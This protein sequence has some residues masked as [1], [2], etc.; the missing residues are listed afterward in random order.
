MRIGMLRLL[1][2]GSFTDTTIDL[3]TGKTDF[4][5]IFGPN[6]AGKSTTLRAIRHM[7]FGIPTRTPDNFVHAYPQLRIGARLVLRD[8]DALDFI[9]RKGQAK[10]LRGLD[11]ETVLD[12]DA[13]TPFLGGVDQDLFEQMFA[14]GHEDLVRGGEE[15]IS[16]K[17]RIGEALFAAG[18]GLIRLQSVQQGLEQACGELFK[19]SGQAPAIN[20][21]IAAFKA[22]RKSQKEALLLAGTWQSHDRR[23]RQAQERLTAVQAELAAHRQQEARWR[24]IKEALP[25]IARKKELV[26]DLAS[27]GHVPDLTEDFSRKRRDGEQALMV[28]RRDHTHFL[29]SIRRLDE[30]IAGLEVPEIVLENEAAIEALQHDLGS[31]RKAQKDRPGLEGRRRTLETQAA[32]IIESLD[33][34]PAADAEGLRRLPSSLV[35][36]IQEL[37]Q[38]YERLTAGQTAI[39]AQQRKRRARLERLMARRHS[40]PTPADVSDLERVLK[41]IQAN[42]PLENRRTELDQTIRSLA[43]EQ[44]RR[45]VRQRLWTGD[46]EA[47]DTLALPSRETIDRFADELDAIRRRRQKLGDDRD[48]I[49]EALERLTAQRRELDP[50]DSV[51]SEA[52]LSAAR[53]LRGQGWTLIRTT[54]ADGTVTGADTAAFCRQLG[55]APGLPE[56]FETSMARADG[57]ADRLR[58]EADQV[59][60]KALLA[61]QGRQLED[62]LQRLAEELN[63]TAG[64]EDACMARW[65]QIWSPMAVEPLSPT[66]MRVWV[67]DMT[68][69][70]ERVVEL[71]ALRQRLAALNGQHTDATRSLSGALVAAGDRVDA[72]AALDELVGRAHALVETQKTLDS[73]LS[74]AD[75]EIAALQDEVADGDAEKAAT[76]AE[77]ATWRRAWEKKMSRIGLGGDASPAAALAVIDSLREARGKMGEADVLR[78]RIDGIDRDA[79][80]FINR[81]GSLVR[82][83]APDLADE[84]ADRAAEML[85]ARLKAARK[86][87]SVHDGLA[88]QRDAAA[89]SIR[90]AK[91]RIDKAQALLGTLCREAG[92]E[93]PDL[94]A[95]LE[96]RARQH[97]SLGQTLEAVDEQLRRLS[98]GATVAA[99]TAEVESVDPDRIDTDLAAAL[100]AIDTLEGERSE[101]DQ[102]IGMETAE[103]RRMDGRATA[104]EHAENAEQLLGSLEADVLHYARLKI[105]ALILSR[106]VEQYRDK[107][108][109]PLIR[110]A[111]DLFAR[112]TLGAFERLRAEYDEKGNPIL[113]G[114]RSGSGAQVTVDGMSDGT[115][116]QLYLALRLASLEQ[117]LAGNEPLPFVIDDILLRFDDQRALA[118]LDVLAD[119][120]DSTQVLFFTHHRHLLELAGRSERLAARMTLTSLEAVG[121]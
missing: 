45:L 11:D 106:T 99:F 94:L 52:D 76:D 74:E 23:L 36:E 110:R 102:T 5:L 48:Q 34:G 84:P 60:R 6:E 25:L 28:A 95:D 62:R 26:A 83:L 68:R 107:H 87:A 93:R 32:D 119:L 82:R 29:E 57:I 103:R 67:A 71:R 97:R 15:I 55:D 78:K 101:L 44:G 42:V 43:D 53:D 37:G 86:A 4:H 121:D 22:A 72:G 104:A 120:A 113:M 50:E 108:Q 96:A 30:R 118:T 14:I 105:A 19:P 111:S 39:A 20:R 40:M 12:D 61:S 75:R 31:Y 85:H 109:G 73:R 112:M 92:C 2:Y 89:T 13:L 18:A 59:S 88:E 56:A 117:Y 21:T 114:I 70:A 7:L 58:R 49:G 17:G 115:A 69:I 9:R 54:L 77:L 91:V 1:A 81:V 35:G 66:E 47:V 100:E 8:G 51:P 3:D 63:D 16:G 65:Q 46:L 116:D 38:S 90:D 33:R 41:A 79:N 10:T 24:R 80:D 64:A 98:A 27:L